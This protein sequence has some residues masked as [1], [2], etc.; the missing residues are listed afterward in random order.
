[1]YGRWLRAALSVG[2]LVLVQSAGASEPGAVGKSNGPA[3]GRPD[4]FGGYPTSHILVRWKADADPPSMDSESVRLG[5]AVLDALALHWRV[6]RVEQ[7][8]QG[9]YRHPDLARSGGLDRTY[10]LVVPPGTDAPAMAAAF[11]AAPG[12]E[13]AELDG[14]GGIAATFPNDPKFGLQ[15]NL[16][17]SGQSGGT[18]DADIDAPEAWDISTG[19]YDVVV[20]ELDTGIQAT[21]PEL[22]GR[23]RSGDPEMDTADDPHGH[24]THVAGI[25]GA[26]GNN[27][28][29]VCGVNW[30]VSLVLFKAVSPSGSGTESQCAAAIVRAADFADP[31]PWV[32]SMS[33][34][35]YTGSQTLH[36]AVDYA[37]A[38]GILLVA[39]NGNYGLP[40]VAYPAAF[41][42]CMAVSATDRND[43]IWP[44]SNYGPETDVA[45]PGKDV[46]SLWKNSGYQ[47]LTGT[48]MA[49]PHVSGT[50]ALIWSVNPCLSSGQVEQILI[51]TAEDRG[52]PGKDSRFGYGRINAHAALLA[53]LASAAGDM[54]CDCLVNE[55]DIPAF[56]LALIDP[57]A[58]ADQFPSCDI[59]RADVNADGSVNGGDVEA[60]VSMLAP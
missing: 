6:A 29:G 19:S 37:S 40:M 34:Q 25:I 11:S 47:T 15:W 14:L 1:M 13:F 18:S 50:A 24:G 53:A 2:F 39:A 12:I 9:P 54:N 31:A 51:S 35:Y 5:S 30:D 4:Q 8:F 10:R 32:I 48:S 3:L 52:D 56:A 59:R 23:V 55:A 22:A 33:L 20:A 49:V 21:H 58:Y 46:Y 44:S 42:G 17:N 16:H 36:D 45:A 7:V 41:P 28:D 60:F 26:I 38:A 27:G 57:A 43:A